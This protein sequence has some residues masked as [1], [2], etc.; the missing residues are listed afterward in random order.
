M[1]NTSASID[2]L[3]TNLAEFI[4][5][6]MYGKDRVIIKKYNRDA[7]VLLSIEDYEKLLDPTKRLKKAQWD[8][9]VRKLDE[10]RNIIPRGNQAELSQ[11]IEKAVREVRAGKRNKSA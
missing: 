10:I 11:N 4:G 6:V 2:E 1:I 3:R 7:A 8:Q 5:R 9:T